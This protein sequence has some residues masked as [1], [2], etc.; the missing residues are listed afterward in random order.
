MNEVQATAY[1]Y[2]LCKMTGVKQPVQ[3]K[4][5]G[6]HEARSM[7]IIGMHPVGAQSVVQ[8]IRRKKALAR[9]VS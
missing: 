4:S 2:W 3:T 6:I 8:R 7:N 9:A 5:V 1:L